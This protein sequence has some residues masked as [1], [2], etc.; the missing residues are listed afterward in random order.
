MAVQIL[1]DVFFSEGGISCASREFCVGYFE[2][3]LFSY[4][5]ENVTNLNVLVLH[6][7]MRNG[8]SWILTQNY[9][10]CTQADP[11]QFWECLESLEVCVLVLFGQPHSRDTKD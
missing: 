8:K 11:V 6:S 5:E 10:F 2:I 4:Q 9:P 7:W 1:R 3:S